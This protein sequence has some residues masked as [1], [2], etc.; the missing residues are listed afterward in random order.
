MKPR[1]FLA[2]LC[3][4]LLSLAVAVAVL[5]FL[6]DGM[7]GSAPLMRSLM[8]RYAPAEA[9]GLS[10]E[11]YPAM[12]EMITDYLSGREQVFQFAFTDEQGAVRQCFHA[13]EQ[14]HMAD[15]K[16]L[17]DLCR[18]V[19]LFAVLAVLLL[20]G[21]CRFLRDGKRAVARGILWG[22]L[23]VL[24]AVAALAVWGLV[25]FD[26]LFVLFHQLSFANDL[27]LLDPRTDLLIRLMPT[28]FFIH[29]A[30]LLCGTW[31]GMLLMMAA[32][33]RHLLKRWK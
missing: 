8:E 12:A 23:A 22:S 3:G 18:M 19:L 17:F 6:I 15:C 7:G 10:G 20:G 30:A 25:D 5:A 4:F 28:G 27:W 32:V 26:G 24:A 14:R 1:K 11:H 16:A 13:R 9:T 33:A 29:Y 21:C 2:A 31:L